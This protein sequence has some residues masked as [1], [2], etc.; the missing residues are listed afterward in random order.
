MIPWEIN[1]I[2]ALFF[3]LLML[4]LLA[5]LLYLPV[6]MLIVLLGNMLVG[7]GLL[8][9]FNFFGAFFGLNL[10]I[11]LLTALLVGLLGVPGIILLLVLQRLSA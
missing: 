6:K 1:Q 2:I 5:R 4:Y 3:A 11:N 10:G 8:A 9:L 7:G